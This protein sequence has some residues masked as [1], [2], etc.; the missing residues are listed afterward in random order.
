MRGLPL[1]YAIRNLGRRWL[2][3]LLTGAAC[4]LVGT[5]LVVTAAFVRGLGHSF[6]GAGQADVAI[7][8]SSVAERDVVRSTVSPALEGIVAAT[9]P[10]IVEVGGTKAVSPELHFGTNLHL[11]AA[12]PPD[13]KAPAH[14][15]FVRGIT[16]AAFAVHDSV[17]LLEGTL[18]RTGEVLVGDLVADRIGVPRDVLGVGRTVWFEGG[19]FTVS[20]VFAA[21]GTTIA[22]EIWAPLWELRGLTKRED[23]S[24]VFVR[25][26]DESVFTDL[27]LFTRRRLDLELECIPT[28]L[29][30]REL[31]AYFAPI[32]AL[33]WL[34][35]LMIGA[36]A[37][38]GGANTLNAAV[39]DRA[40][41]LAT[42]RTLGFS[43]FA[44][45]RSLLAESLVLAS[46]GGL[47]GLLF[48]RAALSGQAFQIAMSAF[49]IEVDAVSVLAGLAAV[50]AVGALGTIPAAVRVLRMPIAAALKAG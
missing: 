18:P 21:P 31:A 45:V 33:A 17:T 49:R 20:G 6:A 32:Q 23:S 36:S 50:L 7:L 22:A 42:L 16:P 30:Y 48:A 41:E 47:L 35:S 9:I 43:G 1:E 24:A 8:L 11:G 27:E 44:L 37:L 38:F 39:I 3:T 15:A 5:L 12:P 25:V 10:G 2:R 4:A 29:Y 14:Q 26:A 34:L 13:G 46:A 40:R 28:T 19:T